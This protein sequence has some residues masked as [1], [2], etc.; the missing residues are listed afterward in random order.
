MKISELIEQLSAYPQDSKVYLWVDGER[1]AAHSVDD[2]FVDENWLIEIN[3][4]MD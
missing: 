1:I 3:G 2:S 4:L